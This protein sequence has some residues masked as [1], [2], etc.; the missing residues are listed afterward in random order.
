MS[1]LK[2]KI[3]K[4]NTF[5]IREDYHKELLRKLNSEK[6]KIY[7]GGGKKSIEKLHAKKLIC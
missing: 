3:K 6:E 4:D 5:H 7:L 1:K 2:S